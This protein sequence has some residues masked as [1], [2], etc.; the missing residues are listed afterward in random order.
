MRA[1]AIRSLFFAVAMGI[2]VTPSLSVHAQTLAAPVESPNPAVRENGTPLTFAVASVRRNIT[3]TGSCDPEHFMILPDGFHMANCPLLAVLFFAEVPSDGTTLG[4]STS[5]R[6]VGAPEWMSSEKYDIEA[7]LEEADRAAWQNPTAQKK[8]FPTLLH[9][10]LEERCKL[11]VHRELRE[12]PVYDLVIAKNGPK[13]SSAESTLPA[14]ILAKHP[15]VGV[16]PGSGGMFAVGVGGSMALYGVSMRTLSTVLSNRAG[17]LVVDKTGL[18]GLYDIHLDAPEPHTDETGSYIFTMLQ[19]KFG[20]KL[21]SAK[22]QV[23]T[24]VIDHIE[25]PSEN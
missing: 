24:L 1:S 6:T 23:E 12:R 14:D 18:T 13:L 22:E 21:V 8:M 25:R 19:E 15:G 3:G 4:F 2:A 17:R 5:G 7:R 9:A 11:A 20:L 10:L 16:V